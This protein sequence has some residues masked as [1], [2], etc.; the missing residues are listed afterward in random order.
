MKKS[1]KLTQARLKELLH[2]DP[3]IGIFTRKITVANNA[4]K[5]DIVGCLSQ[6][7]YLATGIDGIKYYL[8]R[9]AWLYVYGYFP[10]HGIDHINRI[11]TDNRICNLREVTQQCN[12]RNCKMPKT[13]TS[14]VKG[15][16]WNKYTNK[17]VVQI[18]INNKNKTLGSHK[19]FA[20]AVCV[21][22]AVEQ[23]LNWGG[24]DDNSPAYQYVQKM[25]EKGNK[26]MEKQLKIFGKL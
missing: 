16:S 26:K 20:E 12:L 10:E 22:L 24:C 2:Y 1:E 8:H 18:T 9:L 5:G 13:N 25:L 19:T 11:K 3:E 4:K 17:W 23:C 15:V 14:G 21:R 7:G 6:R